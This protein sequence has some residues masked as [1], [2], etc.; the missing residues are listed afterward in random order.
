VI[1]GG[2]FRAYIEEQNRSVARSD[3]SRKPTRPARRNKI[4]GAD[5]AQDGAATALNAISGRQ[6]KRF[7][8]NELSDPTALTALGR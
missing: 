3:R 8:G 1:I 7:E 4:P 6:R 2:R 5:A